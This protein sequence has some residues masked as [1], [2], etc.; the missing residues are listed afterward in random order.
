MWAMW[1]N[2]LKNFV[3]GPSVAVTFGAR[4]YPGA[5]KQNGN[6]PPAM[7]PTTLQNLTL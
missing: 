2:I 3:R 5:L 6:R 4:P 7:Q 1:A